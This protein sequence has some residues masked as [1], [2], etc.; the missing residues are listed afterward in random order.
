MMNEEKAITEIRSAEESRRKALPIAEKR[1]PPHLVAS[2]FSESGGSETGAS[3]R[4]SRE[5]LDWIYFRQ[6]I[7]HDV[8]PSTTVE[9][10]GYALKT[11]LMI[12]P[13][14]SMATLF[15][16]GVGKMC[17]ATRETGSMTWIASIPRELL[18]KYTKA[19]PMVYI[20]KPLADRDQLFSKLKVA[21][22]E[23]CV[24]VGVDVDSG[25]GHKRGDIFGG[26]VGPSGNE[27]SRETPWKPLSAEE[28]REIRG[29]LSKPFVVKGVLSVEDAEKAVEAGA[30]VI[31]VSNHYGVTLDYAQA[32]LEVLPAIS[33]A[34]RDRVDVLVD[35]QM[36]RGTDVLKALALGGRAVLV[37]RPILWAALVGG[38][39]GMAH[40]IRLMTE[41]LRRAMLFTGVE[42]STRVPRDILVLPSEI[43]DK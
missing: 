37:G 35:C 4:R 42:S 27:T 36:R 23:G 40:L 26:S 16:D 32:P 21:E 15:E 25:G 43:F 1:F 19:N 13:M 41:E 22:Q 31:V 34:V 11:P 6:R 18:R 20:E 17:A 12:A 39:K 33:K 14:A 2:W 29:K 10:L 9:F 28:L 30:D 24:A 8:K 3:D 7:I 5:V 38:S